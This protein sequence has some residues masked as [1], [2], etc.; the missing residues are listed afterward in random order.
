MRRR[1]GLVLTITILLA[2]TLSVQGHATPPAIT[3]VV[4][5]GTAGQNGWYVSSVTVRF[6]IAGTVT[7]TSGCDVVTLTAEGINSSLHCVATGPDGTAESRPVFKIDKTPP[8]VTAETERAPNGEGWF[9]APVTVLFRGADAT[10]GVASCSQATYGG[11]DSAGAAVT[12]TCRD[13][14]GNV[15]SSSATL[16]YDA[17]PPSVSASPERGPD[18]NGWYNRP[19]TVGFG[20]TDSVSGIAACTSATYGGPDAESASLSGSCTDHAGNTASASFGLKYDSS[21]PSVADL[22]VVPGYREVLLRWKPSPDVAVVTVTREAMRKGA[23]P[24]VVYRGTRSS[25]S[26]AKLI[27]GVR[28]RYTVAGSDQ[29][30]NTATARVLAVP[31]ALF[32]PV[33]GKKLKAPP[34]LRWAA[35]PGASFYN[36]QLFRGRTKVLSLWPKATKLRLQRSWTYGGREF[37]LEP[38]RYRWYVWPALG[39]GKSVRYA[40]MLG[41]S[42][43]FVVR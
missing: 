23:R 5:I 40:P 13:A 10:S 38:G 19:L 11:P 14:A 16:R 32:G 1:I 25:I 43:F 29:A 24:T 37:T 20:G 2:L 33:E 31:R 21:P 6:D 7:S 27:N 3:P 8:A 22:T 17:T 4:T 12:G 39:K 26:D 35:Y 9:S 36:V 42:F 34:L 41:G 30:G 18:A 28:Y 15:S